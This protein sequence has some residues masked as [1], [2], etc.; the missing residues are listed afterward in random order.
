MRLT[1]RLLAL[2]VAAVLAL[3]LAPASATGSALSTGWEPVPD[4]D[5]YSVAA[6]HT[7]ITV[8]EKVNEVE[9]RTTTARDG[10]VRIDYRGRYV[11]VV[12]TPDHRS[13]TL[14]NSG[15]YSEFDYPNGD[16]YFDIGAPGLIVYYD[17]VERAAFARA[18]LPPVFYYTRGELK[19][20]V[21][22]GYE[23]VVSRPRHVTSVC[24]LLRR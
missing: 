5:D 7:T 21:G 16:T 22:D 10:T 20:Y 11:V 3:G 12:S 14:N 23:R 13:V 18:G 4:S 8:H 6:C 9:S 19:L 17:A 24:D 15:A 2:S 1:H